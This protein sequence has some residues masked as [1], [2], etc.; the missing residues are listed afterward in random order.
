MLFVRPVDNFRSF[1]DFAEIS[2]AIFSLVVIRMACLAILSWD[3][4]PIHSKSGLF[5]ALRSA[6]V[7]PTVEKWRERNERVLS[8]AAF[9]SRSC[10]VYC[11]CR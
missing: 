7:M 10:H 5:A 4:A 2:F 6:M 9:V 1:W 3:R 8:R 11:M